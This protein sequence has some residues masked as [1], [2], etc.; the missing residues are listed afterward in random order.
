MSVWKFLTQWPSIKLSFALY[1]II[2]GSF[3]MGPKTPNFWLSSRLLVSFP[4]RLNIGLGMFSRMLNVFFEVKNAHRL[5]LNKSGVLSKI[6]INQ[7]KPMEVFHPFTHEFGLTISAN[8]QLRIYKL[9]K[10]DMSTLT[11]TSE[12]FLV[13]RFVFGRLK[14]LQSEFDLFILIMKVV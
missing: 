5:L 12:K 9:V 3:H 8:V 4:I 13:S 14:S 10:N 2:F 1:W 7:I 6:L 11:Y